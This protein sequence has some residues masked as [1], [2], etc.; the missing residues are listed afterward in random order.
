[1]IIEYN[2]LESYESMGKFERREKNEEKY[3]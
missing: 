1:M 2:Q 3:L